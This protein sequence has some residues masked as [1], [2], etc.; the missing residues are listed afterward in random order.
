MIISCKKIF[1]YS[2]TGQLL[3]K[4]ALQLEPELFKS[5]QWVPCRDL[6]TNK[7]GLFDRFNTKMIIQAKY[8]AVQV[9]D[10]ENLAVTYAGTKMGF[11]FDSTA[12]I[13][14]IY[15]NLIPL[16][17][18]NNDYSK[19][20]LAK[21]ENKWGL[22]DAAHKALVPI[23]HD[24]L[25][26]L[27]N[28]VVFF[29][30]KQA[31][32]Y[33][34]TK[35]QATYKPN[36]FKGHENTFFCMDDSCHC[37]F[38]DQQGLFQLFPTYCLMGY[39][40]DNVLLNGTN[41]SYLYSKAV[42][43]QYTFG[44]EEIVRGITPWGS[45]LLQDKD[46]LCF[47]DGAHKINFDTT[48]TAVYFNLYD[49]RHFWSGSSLL[50]ENA[51]Y[52]NREWNYR[53]NNG[54]LLEQEPLTNFGKYYKGLAIVVT[55]N[56]I[57]LMD[58]NGHWVIAPFEG[59]LTEN[60][61]QYKNNRFSLYDEAGKLLHENF[62][63]DITPLINGYRFFESKDSIGMM[64]SSGRIIAYTNR[65]SFC[66]SDFN[67]NNYFFDATAASKQYEYSEA[68]SL[69]QNLKAIVDSLNKQQ[70]PA[71]VQHF[72][73][74]YLEQ[75]LLH[76]ACYTNSYLNDGSAKAL[77]GSYVECIN[78]NWDSG[79]DY[80]D[81]GDLSNIVLEWIANTAGAEWLSYA[82]IE[83]H[84]SQGCRGAGS[85]EPFAVFENFYFN[86]DSLTALTLDSLF[87]PNSNYSQII[88]AAVIKAIS[89]YQGT[90]FDCHN[91]NELYQGLEQSFQLYQNEKH[92]LSG[93][94]FYFPKQA[95]DRYID[96]DSY[97]TINIPLSDLSA[98]INP[99]KA[100]RKLLHY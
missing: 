67:L 13:P 7:V 83:N 45:I 82:Y 46:H 28:A 14:C 34:L 80:N 44:D 94:S 43:L 5:S 66:K 8:D 55:E 22:I 63:S 11:Y 81:C 85:N 15:N 39:L 3:T 98:C 88:T 24:T 47:F 95:F 37:G 27:T 32:Y 12:V 1:I 41:K 56:K 20:L 31:Y 60:Y 78:P 35:N 72:Y 48:C 91:L 30:N 73:T 50:N 71:S 68:I 16:K 52:V 62:C 97:L 19:L 4:Q 42:Q 29:S 58:T 86:G 33:K 25:I 18:E 23:I 57:G 38:L 75:L 36:Y 40:K 90:D 76:Y 51:D 17:N 6:S 54:K 99:N 26:L 70:L 87:K 10:N 65:T 89:A 21:K 59:N 9:I 2:T 96:T 77:E 53:L 69:A 79:F 61:I 84:S 92:E 100:W 64:D 93:L 49:T 74:N